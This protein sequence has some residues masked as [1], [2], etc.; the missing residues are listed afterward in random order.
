MGSN[1]LDFERYSAEQGGMDFEQNEFG[2]YRN[3]N[4]NLRWTYWQAGEASARSTAAPDKSHRTLPHDGLELLKVA[5]CPNA[6]IGCVDGVVVRRVSEEEWEP[7]QCQW[8]YERDAFLATLETSAPS[9]AAP[10]KSLLLLQI[11]DRL[12]APTDDAPSST[13]DTNLPLALCGNKQCD[14]APWPANF[15]YSWP[16]CPKC[17]ETATQDRRKSAAPSAGKV[18]TD[19]EVL[20]WLTKI[21]EDVNPT[22]VVRE[23]LTSRA[24]SSAIR[25]PTDAMLDAGMKARTAFYKRCEDDAIGR[26]LS[27][28]TYVFDGRQLLREEFMAMMASTD[29]GTNG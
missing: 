28:R 4:M 17:N 11:R 8:C 13:G 10:D 19:D 7:Q 9:T 18:P 6:A 14:Q 16:R 20:A 5:R 25:A 24:P 3:P 1:R 2:D 21:Y 27:G 23:L 29:G 15:R 26:G 22:G 12:N